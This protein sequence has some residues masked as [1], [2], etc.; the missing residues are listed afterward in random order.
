MTTPLL[1]LVMLG[2]ASG[3]S[4]FTRIQV[5]P[6]GVLHRGWESE[7]LAREQVR[8]LTFLLVVSRAERSSRKVLSFLAL[9]ESVKQTS[10]VTISVCVSV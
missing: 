8:Q 9:L 5:Q 2:Q 6:T 3:H 10:A 1:Y 7:Y 4:L